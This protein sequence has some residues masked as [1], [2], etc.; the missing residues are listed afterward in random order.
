MKCFIIYLLPL[1]LFACTNRRTQSSLD[2]IAL[3]VQ[4]H[5]DSALAKLEAIDSTDLDNKA[6]KAQYSL[7]YSMALDKNYI[8]TTDFSVIAPALR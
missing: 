2:E 8:D 1:L 5:P 4:A 3:L 6:Q 7:L